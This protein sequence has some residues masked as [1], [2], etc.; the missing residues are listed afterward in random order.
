MKAPS[1]PSSL[2]LGSNRT[3][4]S[5]EHSHIQVS[6]AGVNL[7]AVL[8]V[9]SSRAVSTQNI[10]PGNEESSIREACDHVLWKLGNM[11]EPLSAWPVACRMAEGAFECLTEDIGAKQQPGSR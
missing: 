3:S 5:M 2:A 1:A 11:E 4:V 10:V 7:E 8:G 6:G 9:L